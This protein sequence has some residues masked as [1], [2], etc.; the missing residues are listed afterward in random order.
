VQPA[1][2]TPGEPD[3]A[4]VRAMWTTVREKVR[5]RSRSLEAMLMEATVRGIEGDTLILAHPAPPLAKRLSEQHNADV[6][7]EALK[8]ALGVNWRVR[9]D[10]GAAPAGAASAAPAAPRPAAPTPEQQAAVE[11]AEEEDML[12]DAAN[13]R[14]TDVPRRD[15]EEV[16]LELLKSELGARPIGE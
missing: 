5:M 6:I 3:A 11:R 2:A 7:R 1:A 8:D 10:A 16:A 12:A 13:D 9:C 15:P 14:G 4:A